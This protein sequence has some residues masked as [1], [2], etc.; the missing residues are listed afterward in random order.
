MIRTILFS[1]GTV[2]Q[3]DNN[4]IAMTAQ[5][6][7][8]FLNILVIGICSL[9]FIWDLMLVIWGFG[10][11]EGFRIM[12]IIYF[13]SFSGLGYNYQI[14]FIVM[15]EKINIKEVHKKR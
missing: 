3:C 4:Q 11:M 9:L 13:Y 10:Y 2:R 1:F 6:I 8:K 12:I 5:W 15:P 7:S 14:F